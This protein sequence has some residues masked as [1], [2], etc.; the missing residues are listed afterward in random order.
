MDNIELINKIEAIQKVWAKGIVDIGEVVHKN[1]A[2][3]NIEK[4]AKKMLDTLYDFQENHILFKPTLAEKEPFRFNYKQTLSYF[5]GSDFIKEDTGFALT[6]WEKVAFKNI[7]QENIIHQD[8]DILVMGEYTFTNYEG[9]S[10]T[11][12]Y[13]FGYR[14]SDFRI[15]LHHSS[16]PFGTTCD[17]ESF[18]EVAKK[19]KGITGFKVVVPED[20]DYVK[21]KEISNSYFNHTPK[22]VAFPR[23]A[24]QVA[25][26]IRELIKKNQSRP[27]DKKIPL[28]IMSGGH[29]HEGM[30]SVDNAFIIRLSDLGTIEYN[31]DKTE[32][33]IPSGMK[34]GVV[35][36]ELEQYNKTIP[37]GGCMNVNVGGLT[38]GGGWGMNARKDGL[39]CDNILAVE[40]VLA[41]GDVVRASA[42][43]HPDLFWAIRG[44]GG[45]N[46]GVVTRFLFKLQA[47][48]S[49]IC[50]FRFY[51]EHS[52]MENAITTFLEKQKNFPKELTSF[53]RV[54]AIPE[55]DD[56]ESYKNYPVYAS[57]LYH[58]KLTDLV[59]LLE[60]FAN[61][62]KP[63]NIDYF[64][65]SSR[66][67][68]DKELEAV[69]NF[70]GIDFFSSDQT[71]NIKQDS[72]L[73]D[74]FNYDI[75]DDTIGENT[76]SNLNKDYHVAPPRINCSAPHPHKVSSAF[77]NNSGGEYYKNIA[78][79]ITQY[80]KETIE[81]PYR[82]YLPYVRSYMTF[83][84]F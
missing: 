38:Q 59:K 22:A 83:G 48:S 81:G 78:R 82:K 54:T 60:P 66:F 11:V 4:R 74:L 18:K 63:T 28:R 1:L 40:V 55:P 84:A 3:D 42:E 69:R 76:K 70:K 80:F 46:F 64:V 17:S 2:K 79:V 57:G 47:I 77:S 50:V 39:S 51:W 24:N 75:F 53:L 30:S 31:T 41:S 12:E 10:T 21:A 29:Q 49:E 71:V 65:R 27:E 35:Y 33:W 14:G 25:F 72:S 62:A 13:T 8:C 36:K 6:P 58:G 34:L 26:T 73:I 37:G 19:E 20:F 5:I 45:G 43:N 52:G 56:E 9:E 16:L 23:A 67:Y 7:T 61:E 15:F 44:G 68:T 32:A